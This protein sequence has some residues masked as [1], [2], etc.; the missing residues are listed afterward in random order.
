MQLDPDNVEANVALGI[1]D[2]QTNEG[3]SIEQHF[4]LKS[5]SCLYG[6]LQAR[7]SYS[8]VAKCA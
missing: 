5:L 8:V 6:I 2:I 1:M 4:Y 7:Q 3:K